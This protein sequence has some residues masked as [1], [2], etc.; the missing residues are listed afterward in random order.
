MVKEYKQMI[1]VIM[2]AILIASAVF[3][4]IFGW[5]GNTTE[6]ESVANQLKVSGNWRLESD[7]VRPPKLVCLDGGT[8]PQVSR[9]WVTDHKLSKEDF[10]KL[11]ENTGWNFAIEND[12]TLPENVS[13]KFISTCSASG[14]I[15]EFD[16]SIGLSEDS[17]TPNQQRISLSVRSSQ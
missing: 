2:G 5:Q 6:I 7:Q 15:E 17:S 16:V 1:I 14:K 11:L 3:I 8:C 12:C 10:A 9:R 4:G 13:G